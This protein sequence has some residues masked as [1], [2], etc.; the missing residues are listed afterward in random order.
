MD[1][2]AKTAEQQS[3]LLPIHVPALVSQVFREQIANSLKYVLQAQ[4]INNVK[5]VERLLDRSA[6]V[7]VHATMVILAITVS[8]RLVQQA[9]T[10]NNVK[11]M[12]WLKGISMVTAP[13]C[14]HNNIQVVTVKA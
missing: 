2:H 6:T 7:T 14:V 9:P 12:E 3:V 10:T 4:T 8:T 5:M 1:S 11:T 13:V